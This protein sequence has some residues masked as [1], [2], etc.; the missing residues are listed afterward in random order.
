MHPF[1]LPLTLEYLGFGLMGVVADQL[2]ACLEDFGM[3]APDMV[4]GGP[5]AAD[6]VVD[7]TIVADLMAF[8]LIV[9]VVALLM[10]LLA[11]LANTQLL[12]MPVMLV[13]D[14]WVELCASVVHSDNPSQR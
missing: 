2:V 3:S 9:V 10:L 11:D 7:G 5:I 12:E 4:A 14:I 1:C 8:G 13:V 6:M